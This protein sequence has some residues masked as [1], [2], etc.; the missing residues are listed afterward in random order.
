VLCERERKREGERQGERV[1]MRRKAGERQ[2][3]IGG[4]VFVVRRDDWRAL[5]Y[6][7]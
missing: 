2:G 4:G 3:V 7:I 1:C 6:C 5:S